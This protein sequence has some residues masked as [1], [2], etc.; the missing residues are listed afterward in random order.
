MKLKE[1]KREALL[2]QR[3]EMV[4]AWRSSEQTVAERCEEHG[5]PVA[6][7]YRR[8]KLVW[9]QENRKLHE[10][11]IGLQR[12]QE[13]GSL[14]R[15]ILKRFHTAKHSGQTPPW[16][17]RLPCTKASGAWKSGMERTQCCFSGFWRF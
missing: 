12:I 7:Y 13:K 14:L 4:Q 5:M 15:W 3:W 2:R 16:L 6:T 17:H 10:K 8:Q 11:S 1:A 9:E